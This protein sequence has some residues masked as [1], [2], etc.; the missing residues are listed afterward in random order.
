ME[1]IKCYKPLK[2]H[3]SIKFPDGK[4]ISPLC[5]HCF[6]IYRPEL[7]HAW[8]KSN[9]ETFIIGDEGGVTDDTGD[10]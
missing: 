5:R 6:Q 3:I 1:C 2:R 8:E 7:N 10:N 9:L 4:I